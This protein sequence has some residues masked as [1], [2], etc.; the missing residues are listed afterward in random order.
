MAIRISRDFELELFNDRFRQTIYVDVF[1]STSRRRWQNSTV[2]LFMRQ[3]HD[4][5]DNFVIFH[6]SGTELFTSINGS[7][8]INHGVGFTPGGGTSPPAGPSVSM[9]TIDPGTFIDEVV[10]W[11]DIDLPTSG[12]VTNLYNLG[13]SGIPMNQYTQTFQG[14]N[15]DLTMHINGIPFV[16]AID[17][18]LNMYI[19]GIPAGTTV[20]QG[21]TRAFDKLIK[22]NDFNPQII[23]NLGTAATSV[24]IEVWNVAGGA[25]VLLTLTDDTCFQ[26]GDTGRWRWSTANLPSPAAA[27][28]Q[29]FFIMTTDLSDTAEGHFTLDIPESSKGAHPSD[30]DDYILRI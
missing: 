16:T 9:T 1:G 30:Q 21:D 17:D 20:T 26:I 7:G 10:M 18:D 12:E 2:D 25:N 8:F 22:S 24:T 19:E 27:Q 4:R 15:N 13:L 23:G 11:A 6:V 28:Q 5:N 14:V 3:L 29:Y